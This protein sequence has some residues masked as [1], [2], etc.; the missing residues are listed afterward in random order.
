M[1]KIKYL[2]VLALCMALAGCGAQWKRKFVRKRNADRPEQV[3]VYEAKDYQKEPSAER[4][5]K[6][7]VFWKAWMEELIAK[8]GN[9]RANDIRSFE[10][11]LKN[12]EEMKYCLKGEKVPEIDVY[13]GKVK[14]FYEKYKAGDFDIIASQQMRQDLDRLTLKM[15]KIFRYTRM[16]DYIK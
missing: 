9:N 2:I 5:Q 16:Q 14:N 8:L 10:E 1:K 3:F 11:S 4:Y 12:L 7:F 6:N 13:I 15:D